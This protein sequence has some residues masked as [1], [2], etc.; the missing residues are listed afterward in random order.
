M[1]GEILGTS[2]GPEAEIVSSLEGKDDISGWRVIS[3]T[4][5]GEGPAGRLA[6]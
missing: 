2:W 3:K 6:R 4:S 1:A 5:R